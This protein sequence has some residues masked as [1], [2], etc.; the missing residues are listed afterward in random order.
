MK[1]PKP[2]KPGHKK[3]PPLH[4]VSPVKAS[5][6]ALQPYNPAAGAMIGVVLAA[7]LGGKR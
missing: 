1:K 3:R 4:P 7:A 2:K 5:R 6:R